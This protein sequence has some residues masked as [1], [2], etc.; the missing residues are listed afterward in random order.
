MLSPCAQL[1]LRSTSCLALR[2]TGLRAEFG[3]RSALRCENRCSDRLKNRRPRRFFLAPFSENLMHAFPVAVGRTDFPLRTDPTARGPLSA[4]QP[5]L[6]GA[7]ARLLDGPPYANGAPHLGH[8]LNKHLKDAMARAWAVQGR[9]VEWRPGWD[10]HGLPLEVAVERTGVDRQDPLR[11]VAAAR[12][13]ADGQAA[14]QADVF[15]A[16]GWCADW[17]RPW[18]TMDPA[19]ERHTLECLADL[20]DR[21][22]LEMRQTAV[23]WCPTCASTV[24]G[25]EQEDRRLERDESVVPFAVGSAFHRD[26]P[27]WLL[28]WTSTPWTLPL[29]QALVV[30]PDALY[31]AL[32][33][34][35]GSLAWVSHATAEAWSAAL[36]APRTGNT[37]FGA[38]WEGLLYATPWGQG[39]VY[40][41]TGV[42]ADAGTGVL[43][44]VPGLAAFDT[45][46]GRTHGWAVEP[47]LGA[48]GRLQASPCPAQV[49]LAAGDAANAPVMARYKDMPGWAT[50]RRATAH[51]HCWRHGV[52]LLTR[53][54]RQLF[55]R[56][57][58]DVRERALAMVDGMA[59][60][61]PAAQARLRA[62]M[63]DRPD[64][65]LSRQR[66]WG[67][68]VAMFLDRTT[69]QPHARAAVWMRR[70]A[71]AVGEKG[72]E[73]WW[74]APTDHWL[75]GEADAQDLDRVDDVLDV[76]FDS[77]C[78]PQWAGV[79][80][81]VVE[82]T[83]QHRGWFQACVWVAAALGRPAPFARVVTH[84][85][86]L[87][88]SGAKLS[89]S[90]SLPAAAASPWQ[91]APTDVVRAWALAGSVG[92]DKAWTA[93]TVR[94][95]EA[96]VRRWRGTLRFLL[97]NVLPATEAW[98]VPHEA[99]ERLP[100][101]D[102]YWWLATE[103]MA[104]RVVEAAADGR[105]DE[106][107]AEATAYADVFSAMCL[108]SW[109]DRLYC[110]PAATAERKDLD[111]ALKA[112]LA[113]WRPALEVLA[114]RLT[115]E[116]YAHAPTA[117][118]LTSRELTAEEAAEVREVLDVRR[119]LAGKT[120]A[121]TRAG[122]PP[123]HRRV[124]LWPGAPRWPGQLLADA[125]D[126]G[127][128]A[129][130]MST[131][132]EAQPS[133]HP[134]CHRC[135]RASPPSDQAMCVRCAE[136]QRA[137]AAASTAG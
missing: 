109:K 121:L 133:P 68:P 19:A 90:K 103:R 34:P 81:A 29:N 8:V 86:V 125:L 38:A 111:V 17:D 82:G 122:T 113:A 36:N 126:V 14:G 99:A 28:S 104:Q 75:N 65:C 12:A 108:Q 117:L 6:L 37:K 115:E 137:G 83:D 74:N 120:E 100:V 77:G 134:A 50:W 49:G 46:L 25:A 52:P 79:A 7:P 97:A 9:R 72:V 71:E 124:C 112:C 32:A 98:L 2:P 70:V 21:G 107:M 114:P 66:T 58:A 55:L 53:A 48:D 101:W 136:R 57:D 30:H 11:F 22:A 56:L 80:D 18:R 96:A 93:D 87:D 54:S 10:C 51:P 110:A 41:D 61:P 91:E 44:A 123:S 24:A 60:T 1:P 94:A 130:P 45:E 85:F 88:S 95:A 89:K 131:V 16:Q 92:H 13:F 105:S 43:H 33:L 40:T 39:R 128:V 84:G 4:W 35:N 42:A 106:A 116:A 15:K 118:G 64:W 69:G 3:E 73:A 27:E 127:E 47:W 67:V 62:A 135:R 102:R 59:F 129:E 23:P 26:A 63:A 5:A 31:E 76:W 78:V 119:T 132:P 20:L